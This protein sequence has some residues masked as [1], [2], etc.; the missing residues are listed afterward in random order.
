MPTF[1]KTSTLPSSPK[2]VF[3]WHARPEALPTLIPP[4]EDV[5]VERPPQGLAP[6]TVVV[7]V[8]RMGPLRLRWVAEHTAFDDRGEAGGTFVD[9]QR[10]GPFRRWVH[11]HDV[12]P[13]PGGGATLVDT[14]EWELPLPPLGRWIAGAWAER[15]IRRMF[16]FRH[17]ATR[18]AV[19]ALG[20]GTA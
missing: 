17:Q 1:T 11:R 4:W 16:D 6:G 18:D 2:E 20:G 3:A 13:A 8:N 14:V 12:S 19:A 10:E 7:L 15:R 5:S 9:V